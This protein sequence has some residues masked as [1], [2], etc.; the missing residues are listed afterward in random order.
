[1]NFSDLIIF[2]KKNATK[3]FVHGDTPERKLCV[4]VISASYEFHETAWGEIDSELQPIIA[5]KILE[6]LEE[7]HFNY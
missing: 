5:Q 7:F 4:V 2:F 1:M 3:I 6:K